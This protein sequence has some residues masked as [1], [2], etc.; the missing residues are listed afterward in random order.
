MKY[1]DKDPDAVPTE[2]CDLG[3]GSNPTN[4]A[5]HPAGVSF[6][7]LASVHGSFLDPTQV[8]AADSFLPKRPSAVQVNRPITLAA[9][10]PE[11]TTEEPAPHAALLNPCSGPA[12]VHQCS[13]GPD[14]ASPT[15]CS[16]PVVDPGSLWNL[17]H[18]YSLPGVQT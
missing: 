18:G 10:V 3:D 15:P 2:S 8:G 11:P 9:F 16:G 5:G 4:G 7:L 13:L 1:L 6:H 14:S 12:T 17:G